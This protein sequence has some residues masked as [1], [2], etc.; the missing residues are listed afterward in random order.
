ML[1]R[2]RSKLTYANVVSTLCLFLLLGG[3]TAWAAKTALID[4]RTLATPR[5]DRFWIS[6]PVIDAFRTCEPVIKR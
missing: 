2:L 3:S 5:T 4:G 1:S 6:T